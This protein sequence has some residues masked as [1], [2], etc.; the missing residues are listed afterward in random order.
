[1]DTIKALLSIKKSLANKRSDFNFSQKL[2]EFEQ[3]LNEKEHLDDNEACQ[4]LY[5]KKNLTSTYKSL[6]YRMEER[7]MNDVFLICSLEDDLKSTVKASIQIE[8]LTIVGQILFKNFFRAEGVVLFEKGL[9]MSKKYSNADLAVRQ[10][11]SLLS[12]Y[13]FGE[14]DQ[15]KMKL[16]MDELD[17]YSE[18]Y[19]CEIYVKKCNAIFSN[20]YVTNKGGF[21]QNQISQM[22]EMVTKMLDIKSKYKSN[23]IVSFVNDLT[24]F[25]YQCIGDYKKGLEIATQGLAE[26]SNLP[27]KELLGIYQSKKN[28]AIA[29]FYLR[30]YSE[31]NKWFLE[32]LDMVTVG[33]R[34]WFNTTSLY[35][36]SL[37]SQRDYNS[38]YTLSAKILSNKNLSKFPYFEEQWKLREAYLNFLIR[39][40]KI[41]I[42]KEEKQVL[43]AFSLSKFMN[44]VPFHSK[45]KS[46]QNISILVIQIL[47]LLLDNKYGQIIDRVDSLTQYTYRYLH[48]N[49]TYRSNCFIKMLLLM[50][51]ADFHP[52]RTQ[53]YSAD[54]K[55]KLDSSHLITDEKSTQVE[56]IPY[57]YL[58]ELIIE[59]L[60]VKN[61][62]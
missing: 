25:Y 31:A 22:E 32:V 61:K 18:L 10:L 60:K 1:M 16:I 11:S 9:K 47:F 49:E 37:I 46:G 43:K 14:P 27:N 48:K 13:S 53:T 59:I 36:L 33:T 34:N 51:K 52:I 29:H 44:S 5:K 24:F 17:Y 54:L 55:Q 62:K 2:D 7:L 42:P 50:V 30:D 41:E 21:N 35:F 15:H 3:L 4:L 39:M 56:I 19:Q 28:I 6:K 8:K 26:N 58:W 45:D 12:H 38:L 23:Y 57:D 40:G 20:L